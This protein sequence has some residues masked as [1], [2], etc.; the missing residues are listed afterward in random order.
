[1]FK[2]FALI[3]EPKNEKAI[4]RKCN[5]LIDLGKVSECEELMKYL[6]EMAI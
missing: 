6:E 1:M 2:E 5:I 3:S 4:M